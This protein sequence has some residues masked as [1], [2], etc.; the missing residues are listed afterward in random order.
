MPPVIII[1][2][3]ALAL[4]AVAANE[5]SSVQIVQ[6]QVASV[7]AA[8]QTVAVTVTG[9]GTVDRGERVSLKVDEKTRIIK[10]GVPIAL[11]ELRRGD[12]VVVNYRTENGASVAISIGVQTS[13]TG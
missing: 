8:A 2:I 1:I 13:R 10:N 9:P 11:S 3:A 6:G 5:P 4:V 7:D 12:V